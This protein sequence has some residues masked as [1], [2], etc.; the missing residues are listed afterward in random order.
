MSAGTNFESA[1]K[2]A[3]TVLSVFDEAHLK[4][5]A[6][7]CAVIRVE[8]KRVETPLHRAEARRLVPE[9]YAD[10]RV[11]TTPAEVAA[12]FKLA[13]RACSSVGYPAQP[14]HE[15][16]SLLHGCKVRRS[17]TPLWTCPTRRLLTASS[18]LGRGTR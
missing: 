1:Y 2:R 16:G 15:Q 8:A 9:G 17:S 10:D 11:P 4:L 14:D 6:G 13:F 18:E 7:F 5:I 12:G 3:L